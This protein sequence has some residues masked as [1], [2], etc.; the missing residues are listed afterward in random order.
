VCTSGACLRRVAPYSRA[1][2]TPGPCFQPG[3]DPGMPA[4][5]LPSTESREPD[6]GLKESSPA[7]SQGIEQGFAPGLSTPTFTGF[8]DT[9]LTQFFRP[10]GGR[11]E[12]RAARR[13][14]TLTFGSSSRDCP[15]SKSR[16]RGALLLLLHAYFNSSFLPVS[17]S[18][19]MIPPRPLLPYRVIASV[20]GMKR[21]SSIPRMSIPSRKLSPLGGVPSTTSPAVT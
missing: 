7:G 20:E 2:E 1:P 9:I 18:T 16:N 6:L 17:E 4:P 3:P 11:P 10:T 12:T 14:A 19:L 13:A 8:S 5:R 15:P 21:I